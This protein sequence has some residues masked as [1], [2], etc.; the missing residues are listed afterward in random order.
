VAK[1]RCVASEPLIVPWLDGRTIEPDQV[2]EVPDEHYDA[3][4]C[5]PTV[6]QPVQEPKKTSARASSKD[7][8]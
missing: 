4:E 5:Q 6:W 1:F 2:V 8:D 7:G 3:Y